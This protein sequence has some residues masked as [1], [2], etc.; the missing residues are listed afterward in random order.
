VST[1]ESIPLICFAVPQEMAGFRSYRRPGVL[2]RTLLTG[3]GAEN[4]TRAVQCAILSSR[5]SLILSCGFAGG[6]NPA[7]PREELVCGAGTPEPWRAELQS[8]GVRPS[9]FLTVTRIV[10]TAIEKGRLWSETG[11][12]VMEM[13]SAAIEQVAR[14][15]RLPFLSIRIVSD[16]WNE[17]LPLDF[18]EVLDTRMRISVARLAIRLLRQPSLVLPLIRLGRSSAQC[19][20]ILG[21]T[22]AHFVAVETCRK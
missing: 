17:D 1:S 5:P 15:H 9:R 8:L 18:Q 3:I 20:R 4:A 6:L 16:A 14:E 7:L 10:S 12:D 2:A 11:A 22:L 19:S 13:E 21:R